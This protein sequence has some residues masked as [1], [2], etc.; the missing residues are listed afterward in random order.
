MTEPSLIL[1]FAL[2]I[3]FAAVL[4][5]MIWQSR[6]WQQS[7]AQTL[8]RHGFT[9]LDP[10]PDEYVRRI[11]A[12]QPARQTVYT[13][14]RLARRAMVDG[15]L[16]LYDM[17]SAGRENDIDQDNVMI[18]SP[19]LDL[20]RFA[21]FPLPGLG[22]KSG[23][24]VDRLVGAVADLASGQTGMVRARLPGAE[25]LEQ[26]FT[27]LAEDEFAVRDFF[28][29]QRVRDLLALEQTFF[30]QA[31]GDA[32]HISLINAQSKTPGETLERSIQIARRLLPL[33]Q[34]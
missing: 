6:R 29:P 19:S 18:V 27:L 12:L 9:R 16:I 32:F 11:L 20:P 34:R 25:E 31:G 2:L 17:R 10:P 22:V 24:V 15:E 4:A 21:L 30:L 5:L 13:V 23:G 3:F 8:A 28:T 33:L 7:R 26:R 14:T 1:V